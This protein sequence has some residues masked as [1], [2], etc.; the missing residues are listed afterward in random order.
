MK[1]AEQKLI[2][3]SEQCEEF[4]DAPLPV[5]TMFFKSKKEEK[6]PPAVYDKERIRGIKSFD[7]DQGERILV[8]ECSPQDLH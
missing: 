6:L 8:L 7:K 5:F 1:L 3:N 4:S 2:S